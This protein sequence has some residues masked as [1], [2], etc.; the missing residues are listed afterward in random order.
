[1]IQNGPEWGWNV[2]EPA[3][4]HMVGFCTDH[5]NGN[6]TAQ[7]TASLFDEHQPSSAFGWFMVWTLKEQSNP[8]A[9]AEMIWCF[10]YQRICKEYKFPNWRENHSGYVQSQSPNIIQ[11]VQSTIG[12][13]PLAA[14][15]YWRTSNKILLQCLIFRILRFTL[16][17]WDQC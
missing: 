13:E 3:K 5:I 1:M 17:R 14:K 2:M 8:Q 10:Q 4:K 11:K 15:I 6:N 12:I 9:P 7:H 16:K